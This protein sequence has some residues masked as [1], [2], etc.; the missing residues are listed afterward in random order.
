MIKL[1]KISNTEN[2]KNSVRKKVHV[3]ITAD[4]SKQLRLEDDGA[5]S[6]FK[7]F[8]WGMIQEAIHT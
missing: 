3:M 8:Y 5:T 6:F 7:Q 4:F 1:Y 2:L